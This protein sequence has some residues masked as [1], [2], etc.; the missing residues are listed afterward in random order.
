MCSDPGETVVLSWLP[1]ILLQIP[2][3][4]MQT[5]VTWYCSDFHFPLYRLGMG[6]YGGRYI[7][8]MHIDST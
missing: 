4:K 1:W 5:L 8:C 7:L 2:S 3:E 6:A